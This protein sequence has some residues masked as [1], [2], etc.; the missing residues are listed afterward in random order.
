MSDETETTVTGTEKLMFPSHIGVTYQKMKD[1]VLKFVELGGSSFTQKQIEERMKELGNIGVVVKRVIPYLKYLGFLTRSRIGETGSFTYKLVPEIRE[2]LEKN[3]EEYDSIFIELCRT[4]PAYLTIC[5]YAEEEKVNK[6][7]VSS[8]EQQY[9]TNKLKTKYSKMGL[10]SWLN[11]LDKVKLLRVNEG[12]ISLEGIPSPSELPGKT[13]GTGPSRNLSTGSRNLP[14]DEGGVAPS[15]AFNVNVDLD[16][17]QPPDLQRDY[18]GWL[19]RMSSKPNVKVS[20]KHTEEDKDSTTA[21]KT[22]QS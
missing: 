15:M 19:E 7:L 18:M 5:K 11:A 14:P 3:A 17:R 21:K 16:Y 12:F 22:G 9:L 13:A 8:F 4:S 1:T 2:R 6:F 10:N 20:I